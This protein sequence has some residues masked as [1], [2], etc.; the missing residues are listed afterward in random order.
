MYDFEFQNDQW[1]IKCTNL[2]VGALMLA[3]M[4]QVIGITGHFS[5]F[6]RLKI[7]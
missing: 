7:I 1:K 5:V 2:Q 4:E 6:V 3:G